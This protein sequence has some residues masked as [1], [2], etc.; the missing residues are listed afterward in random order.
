MLVTIFAPGGWDAL[1]L[2]YPNGD[3]QYRKL[4]PEIAFKPEDGPVFKSDSRLHW[5]P[6]LK[7]LAKM[8]DHGKI[9]VFPAIGYSHP[10]QS[11]FTSRHY[12]EVGALDPQLA[13]AGSAGSST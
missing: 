4:R 8:H 13:P 9:T 3:P 7:P 6:A 12:W 5:H 2:L 11:H 10:D 1:S